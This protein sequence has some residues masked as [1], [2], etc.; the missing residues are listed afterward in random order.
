METKFSDDGS[1][2]RLIECFDRLSLNERN[3]IRGEQMKQFLKIRDQV[4]LF[5]Q[6]N[7]PGESDEEQPRWTDSGDENLKSI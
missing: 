5:Y 1:K 6:K 3:I 4:G 2:R 7:I